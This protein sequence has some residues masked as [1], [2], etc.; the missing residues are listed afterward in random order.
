MA[1]KVK[2]QYKQ[3]GDTKTALIITDEVADAAGAALAKFEEDNPDATDVA[4]LY[5]LKGKFGSRK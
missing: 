4:V 2:I 3:N 5:V 1:A